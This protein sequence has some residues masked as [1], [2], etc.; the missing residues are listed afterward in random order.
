V[1]L[2]CEKPL[3]ATSAAVEVEDP[4]YDDSFAGP[5]RE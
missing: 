1:M 4:T 3:L 5:D 2:D